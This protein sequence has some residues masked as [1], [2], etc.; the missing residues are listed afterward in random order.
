MGIFQDYLDELPE[1][2]HY[3]DAT[4]NERQM[5]VISQKS[6]AK[7]VHYTRLRGMLFC[8]RRKTVRDTRFRVIE[9]VKIVA[10]AILTKLHNDSKATYKY[11]S[12]SKS[13]YCWKK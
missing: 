4:F 2:R 5:T 10:Y 13:E 7:V 3:W 12:R 1:F 8:P 6:G 11:L 9:L